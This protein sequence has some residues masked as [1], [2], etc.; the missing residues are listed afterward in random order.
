M[1]RRK[2]ALGKATIA[3]RQQNLSRALNDEM[4]NALDVYEKSPRKCKIQ[5]TIGG[6]KP[7]YVNIFLEHAPATESIA[8]SESTLVLK[9]VNSPS[10]PASASSPQFAAASAV[11]PAQ[12]SLSR[13]LSSDG[14]IN[15][16]K[17]PLYQQSAAV[18]FWWHSLVAMDGELNTHH[19]DCMVAAPRPTAKKETRTQR[20]PCAERH[21]RW[22]TGDY[23]AEDSLW[24]KAYVSNF[25]VVVVDR[26]CRC[27][28]IHHCQWS[29]FRSI[30]GTRLGQHFGNRFI[31]A[32]QG[33]SLGASLRLRHH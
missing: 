7:F 27:Q 15:I 28:W 1:Q 33:I 3:Y 13:C 14:I 18:A 5:T 11:P 17:Y 2:S 32:M 29:V 23:F 10:S 21:G 30:G 12:M 24:Y 20:C 19:V 31:R 22:P 6:C 16:E 4:C 9:M 8:V 26:C 25:I